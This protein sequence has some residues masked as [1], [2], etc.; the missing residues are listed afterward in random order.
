MSP[1]PASLDGLGACVKRLNTHTIDPAI[2]PPGMCPTHL[3][4]SACTRM[5]AALFT[6]REN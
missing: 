5:Q 6:V 1:G 3:H 4:T 2:P